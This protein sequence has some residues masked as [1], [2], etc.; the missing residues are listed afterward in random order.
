MTGYDSEH[1]LATKAARRGPAGRRPT[2]I[3][4]EWS[5]VSQRVRPGNQSSEVKSNKQADIL[6]SS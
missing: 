4:V 5:T 1:L 6:T 2:K 3:L